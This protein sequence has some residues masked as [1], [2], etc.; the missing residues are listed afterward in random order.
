MGGA[1]E[2]RDGSGWPTLY[3][4]LPLAVLVGAFVVVV[5][6]GWHHYLSLKTIAAHRAELMGLIDER[7]LAALA[8]YGLVYAVVIALSLP[9]GSIMTVAGGFLFGWAIG[10]TVT[11]FAATLGATILFLVARSSLGYSLS[12]RAGPWLGKLQKG[13]RE[14]AL[15]YLLFLRLTPI[16]PFWLVNLAPA[17]LGVSLRTFVLG[18]FI[19]IIPAT[20]AFAVL[21]AGLDSVILAQQ[22]AYE[23]CVAQKGAAACSF[24]IDPAAL[25]TPELIVAFAALGVV[26]LVPVALQKYKARRDAGSSTL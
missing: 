8:G 20:V 19:G 9:G 13:F 11:V 18:T 15:S 24:H 14:H 22:D 4:Y 5:A 2:K 10:S 7:Y 17:L 1:Q 12:S 25:L 21:G 26:A 23:R 3:R 6:A 16:F